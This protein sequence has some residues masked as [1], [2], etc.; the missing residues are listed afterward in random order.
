MSDVLCYSGLNKKESIKLGGNWYDFLCALNGHLFAFYIGF[1][2]ELFH[3]V[4]VLLPYIIAILFSKHSYFLL[5]FYSIWVLK[6]WGVC[7]LKNS[8]K[9]I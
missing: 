8:L 7:N 6:M 4:F 1:A 2:P 3:N 5:S 9:I